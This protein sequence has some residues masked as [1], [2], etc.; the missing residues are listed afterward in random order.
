MMRKIG[1]LFL[2]IMMALQVNAQSAFEFSKAGFL[3]VPDSEREVFDFNVGWRFEK[4]DV[5]DAYLPD[6]DDTQWGIVNCPHGLELVP[7][8][9]SGG[10]NYQGPAWYRKHFTPGDNLKGKQLRLHFEG[11]MG[12]CKVWLNGELIKEHFGGYLPFSAEL[13][14]KLKIGEE[15]VIAVLADNSDDPDF[16]PG[17][18]QNTLDFTYFG[19]IYRDVWLTA[20]N[21]VY[22]T[23]PN[24]EELVAGGGLLVR[25]ENVSDKAADVL[26]S[27]H[28]RN[29]S[30]HLQ[31]LNVEFR[32][33]D[34]NGNVV[35]RKKV[36]TK[37]AGGKAATINGRYHVKNPLLWSPQSPSLYR[38]EIRIYNGQNQLI[39]AVAQNIGIRHMEMRGKDGFWL[40]G[41][42]YPKRLMGVNRH[43]DFAYIGNA[44]PNNGQL[45]DAMLL[46]NAGCDIVRAAHY[47]VDPAF[48]E[49]CD[50]LGMFYIVATPGWQFWNEKPVFEQRVYQDVRNMVRRDR[51]NPCVIMWEP[52]LNET[53]YPDHFARKVHEIVHNELPGES[54]F[55]VCDNHVKG[56]EYF[57]VVYA[58][59]FKGNWFQYPRLNTDENRN[60][61][62]M[63]YAKDDRCVFTREFG[64]FPDDWSAHN[65]PS[66]I[67]RNWGEHGQLV[68]LNHYENPE[69]V[70]ASWESLHQAPKQH[71]GGALWHAFDHQRGYHPDPFYGG[72][73]DVFRQ[74]KY[75]YYLFE[76]QK[77]PQEPMIFI[78]NEM[79][80]M[81]ESEVTVLTNCDEV[82]LIVY[83]KD[84]LYAKPDKE[85]NEMPHPV[86]RFK[87]VYKFMDVKIFHGKGQK[88][89][90]SIVAEGLIDGKVV[91]RHKRMASQ[92]EEHI[93]LNLLD[94]GVPMIANGSD[95]AVVVAS[96]VDKYGNTKRLVNG[97]VHFKIEG[98][99]ELVG[100]ASN[101]G[102]PRKVEWG[103]APILIR[104][105]TKAG[106]IKITASLIKSG[107][108][109]PAA[110]V[111]E[112][113]TK[114]T[115]T[116]L[117]YDELGENSYGAAEG[118]DVKQGAV[119]DS[120]KDKIIKEL[121]KKLIQQRLKEVEKQQDEFQAR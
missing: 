42:P 24:D 3:S 35:A 80:P 36:P 69:F 2:L 40:N 8:E 114:P 30:K 11:V 65:S 71:I 21:A 100:N 22:V 61:M 53:W 115:G 83:E 25:S 64:D 93:V 9:A 84:T 121:E 110:G 44:L 79:T 1:V 95:I 72:I 77:S 17:K 78:A 16:P 18:P 82:R 88:E 91:A 86:V 38:F 107:V 52:I 102:N 66:R 75:S 96:I 112:I 105:S 26:Y 48:M 98:E 19:G 32:L 28:I 12:K 113:E 51:N 59:P 118:N 56:Q 70:F 37:V 10:V 94:E 87:D 101:S 109:V 47:P 119:S 33:K 5:K 54:V 89:K 49:A 55:T 103:D 23:N 6:F 74:K 60:D 116:Q 43:Q 111:L 46:K 92:R 14:G 81:S 50:A 4:A 99:G 45:R 120:E 31:T 34:Q 39:D 27:T 67:A 62:W 104:T 85:N 7:S 68:Q 57:D 76:S 117:L 106:T 13:T 90:A 108:H 29:N 63:D 58:H 41:K 20:T 15:N 97:D 73:T